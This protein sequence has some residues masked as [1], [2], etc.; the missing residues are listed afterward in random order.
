MEY[1]ETQSTFSFNWCKQGRMTGVAELQCYLY[2]ITPQRSVMHWE[3][4]GATAAGAEARF[5]HE[6]IS[7]PLKNFIAGKHHNTHMC[8]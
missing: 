6:C 7:L 2:C 3:T 5:S 8:I 4:E 1:Q